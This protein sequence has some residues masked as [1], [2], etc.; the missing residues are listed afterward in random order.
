MT[1]SLSILL[2]TRRIMHTKPVQ[3]IESHISCPV[4]FFENLAVYFI[5]WENFVEP[6]RPRMTICRTRIE[7]L[8]SKATNTHSEYVLL[9]V[10]HDNN[11]CKNPPLCYVM[12][13]SIKAFM[14]LTRNAVCHV[15]EEPDFNKKTMRKTVR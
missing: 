6:D 8:I 1:I 15:M 12:H 4:I 5:V 14:S 7:C 2:R 9:I 10:F 3:R 11:S 13:S